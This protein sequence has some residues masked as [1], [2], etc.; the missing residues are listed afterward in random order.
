V[1]H[2]DAC[3]DEKVPAQQIDARER[4]VFGADHQGYQEIPQHGGNRRNQEKEHHHLAVHGEKL[5][6]SIGLH[7]VADRRQQ[8]QPHHEGKEPSDEKEERN[9]HEVQ[10][11]D[12]LVVRSEQP[13]LDAVLLVQIVLAFGGD[14]C[15]GHCYCTFSSCD[16]VPGGTVD[17][18]P[19]AME[20]G[21]GELA[22]ATST[23]DCSSLAS[24]WRTSMIG[25]LRRLTSALVSLPLSETRP[26]SSSL[27]A[28]VP[29][30]L[31]MEKAFVR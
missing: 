2:H 16:F 28:S 23:F 8:F 1:Q 30:Q 10:Q 18:P 13:R 6:V 27:C 14:C 20:A 29:P 31:E 3:N 11:R 15:R 19:V 5:V 7:Q 24:P 12:A 9:R 22:Y 25:R 26:V 4:E 21:L 17:A